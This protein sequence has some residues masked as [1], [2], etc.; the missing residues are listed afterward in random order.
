[1]FHPEGPTAVHQL[2]VSGEP[3]NCP[4][5]CSTFVR[6]SPYFDQLP[7]PIRQGHL[8]ERYGFECACEACQ[9]D[10]P[11][12]AAFKLSEIQ[13]KL[14]EVP[15]IAACKLEFKDNCAEILKN[16]EDFLSFD[17][18]R[19]MFRNLCLLSCVARAEPFLF[20]H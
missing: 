10:Y 18:K 5:V 11:V 12:D 6:F 1:M 14:V 4:F 16:R 9:R 17:I 7:R 8:K 15:S 2:R 20:L 19:R 3:S 13:V